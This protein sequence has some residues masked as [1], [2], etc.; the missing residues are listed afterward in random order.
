LKLNGFEIVVMETST[1]LKFKTGFLSK[2]STGSLT[3]LAGKKTI[4]N[5]ISLFVF[6]G[7]NILIQLL[8]VPVSIRFI[9][10]PSYGLWLTISAMIG[11]LSIMDI[12]LANGLRNT[13]TMAIVENKI[14]LAKKYVSTSYALLILISI[15]GFLTCYWFIGHINWLR[16]L[17]IPSDLTLDGFRKILLIVLS[18]FFLTFILKPIASVAYATHNASIEFFIF[19][20]AQ[21][22][23]QVV[24]WLLIHKLPA[25]N[26]LLLSVCFCFSPI[27]VTLLLSVYLFRTKFKNFSPSFGHVDFSCSRDFMGLSGKFFVIQVAALVIMNSN[28]FLIAH[29]LGNE[30]V[31]RY[32]I[33]QRYFNVP[34]TIIGMVLVP[35]WNIFTE[36]YAKKNSEL[37]QKMMRKLLVFASVLSMV[38]IVMLLISRMVYKLW[39]GNLVSVPFDM[40]LATCIYSILLIFGSV[41]A[42]CVNG[43]GKVRLHML[44]SLFSLVLHIPIAIVALKYFHVETP[45]LLLISSFWIVIAIFLRHLQYLQLIRFKEKE[46]FWFR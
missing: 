41:Y 27:V 37:L 23:K 43:T 40:N 33:V 13:L 35:F 9:S 26:I 6:R 21:F 36:A 11:W 32:N 46:S 29:Y 12:G 16:W 14:D 25:G 19:F 44:V 34:F 45:G 3:A 2:V 1:F 24:L 30:D 17:D 42:T 28:I 22:V 4:S 5:I 20:C 39:I 15:V 7:G 18:S 8:L 31:A 38:C 10:A